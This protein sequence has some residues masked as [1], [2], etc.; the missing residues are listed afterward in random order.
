MFVKIDIYIIITAVLK[1]FY[2]MPM[3]SAPIHHNTSFKILI[4]R[5]Q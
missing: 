3:P 4:P 1:Y 5:S 2:G